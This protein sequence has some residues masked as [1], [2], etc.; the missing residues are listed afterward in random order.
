MAT[1]DAILIP[2][3]SNGT[4]INDLAATTASAVQNVGKNYKFAIIGV[5][6]I[7]IR[8]GITDSVTDPTAASFLIP[9]NTITTFDTGE[10]Y[11]AFKVFNTAGTTTDIHYLRLSHF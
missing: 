7:T 10:T 1:F 11:S 5:Q 9:A 8:F 4:Q 6:A 3:E 2:G